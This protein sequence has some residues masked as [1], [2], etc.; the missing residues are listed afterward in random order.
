MFELINGITV[1]A[2]HISGDIDD[3]EMDWALVFSV[4]V[5]RFVI[6]KY[7]TEENMS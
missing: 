7:R 1:G 3:D 4:F 2:E 6:I 5:L